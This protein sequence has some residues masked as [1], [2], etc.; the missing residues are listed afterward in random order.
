M[1][2]NIVFVVLAFIL[3]ACASGPVYYAKTPSE[4]IK[5]S[6]DEKRLQDL[7]D[8]NKALL[9]ELYT[10]FTASKVDI[11]KEGLG[12]TGLTS[13]NKERLHYLMV[14]VR[15][16]DIMYKETKCTPEE[17]FG[18]VLQT[19]FPKY[20]K[21]MKKKDLDVNDVEGLL[22]GVYWP[23]R[24]VC[25]TYGGFLEYIEIYFSQKDVYEFLDGKI[26]FQEAVM[27][28]EVITSLNMG[29]ATSVKPVFK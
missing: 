9:N 4:A 23:V 13:R 14:K 15:P 16:Q 17:R 25:D 3:C 2:R 11:Y 20:L 5:P 7:Y 22:F 24:D 19:Y 6:Y 10:R 21:M 28:S 26:T 18:E 29:P 12:F 27:D 8:Q 1:K